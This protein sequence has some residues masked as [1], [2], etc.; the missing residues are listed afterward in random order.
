MGSCD[1]FLAIAAQ[2]SVAEIV[3]EDEEDVGLGGAC[4]CGEG[5]S[6]E[7]GEEVPTVHMNY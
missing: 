1:K 5:Q 7:G 3:C 6:G 2:V 4:G